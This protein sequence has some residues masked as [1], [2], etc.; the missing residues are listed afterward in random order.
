MSEG[1]TPAIV[2]LNAAGVHYREWTYRHA[3]DAASYGEEAA[4]SLGRDSR[5]VFKTLVVASQD[6]ARRLGVGV[7]P[8]SATLDMKSFAAVMGVRKAALAPVSL[9]ERT[10]GYVIGGISPL[11]QKKQLPTIIDASALAW[12]T[13]LVSAGRKGLEIEIAPSDLAHLTTATFA[14]ISSPG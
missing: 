13:I 10:S 8:V 11:G 1:A 4:V 5:Q 3:P 14:N 9:A 12:P 7:V 2:A 6:S